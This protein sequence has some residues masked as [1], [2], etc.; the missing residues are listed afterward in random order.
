MNEC[1][2]DSMFQTLWPSM[3]QHTRLLLIDYDITQYDSLN[4]LR[5]QLMRDGGDRDREHF[6][7]MRPEYR[8]ILNPH[9]PIIDMVNFMRTKV[10]DFNIYHMF[11]KPL[12]GDD[13]RITDLSDYEAKLTAMFSYPKAKIIQTDLAVR[14]GSVFHREDTTGFLLR[15]KNNPLK[16]PIAS[17]MTVIEWD[18]ILDV[19]K[20]CDLIIENNINAV[21][22][23]SV[24][25]SAD[26]AIELVAR[27]YF[28]SISWIIG[29]YAYNFYL[30]EG[31]EQFLPKN[32]QLMGKLELHLKYEYGYIDTFPNY[33]NQLRLELREHRQEEVIHGSHDS[34][35][36]S[37]GEQRARDHQEGGQGDPGRHQTA[38][39][40]GGQ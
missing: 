16:P 26:I 36:F 6:M 23:S 33:T 18:T 9:L 40:P 5:W 35:Q 13:E 37:E 28:K 22:L 24:A 27:K 10:F 30:G 1:Y 3:I 12:K 38:A 14:L 31:I 32:N 21:M 17:E 8:T 19:N 29:Q 25:F 39:G 20:I 11:E 15:Y 7:S 2:K 34:V 4:L